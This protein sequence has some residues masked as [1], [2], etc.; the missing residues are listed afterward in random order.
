MASVH[1]RHPP[2]IGCAGPSLVPVVVVKVLALRLVVLVLLLVAPAAALGAFPGTNGEIA[3][4]DDGDVW[5]VRD[6]ATGLHRVTCAEAAASG[7]VAGVV[8]VIGEI[9][10]REES[11][12]CRVSVPSSRGGCGLR[13]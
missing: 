11:G 5:V 2:D 1:S 13:W 8:S 10:T 6:N 7:C 9:S 4:V 12:G 3:F